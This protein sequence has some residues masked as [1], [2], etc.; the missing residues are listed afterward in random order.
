MPPIGIVLVAHLC[1]LG[2][3]LP[4]ID[5]LRSALSAN[6]HVATMWRS[7]RD[8]QDERLVAGRLDEA[9][10]IA[11]AIEVVASLVSGCALIDRVLHQRAVD[12]ELHRACVHR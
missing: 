3:A 4:A 10:Q 7:G 12:D 5:R 1:P 6:C 9:Q 2:H 8:F 11:A